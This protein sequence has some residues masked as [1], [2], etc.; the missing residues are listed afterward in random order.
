MKSAN[1]RLRLAAKV[2]AALL[3]IGG[4]ALAL[5]QHT[6]DGVLSNF[7][8][9]YY[10]VAGSSWRELRTA[11]YSNRITVEGTDQKWEGVT[12]SEA[13]LQPEAA[14]TGGTCSAEDVSL[15]ID[16]TIKVP[17]LTAD[18]PLTGPDRECWAA[19]DRKLTEHEEWHARIAEKTAKD[20][21]AELRRMHGASCR[22]LQRTMQNRFAE[23]QQAQDEYDL[24]SAHGA[25]QWRAFGL[26]HLPD[27][28]VS[29]AALARCRQP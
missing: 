15:R 18:S 28:D 26:D 24:V 9:D 5:A 4:G 27:D 8:M 21:L 7:R 19:Y 16:M 23:A 11:I 13:R 17:R 2:A 20:L 14:V 22:T 10:D 29:K 3:G 12:R 6:A 25:A 1:I